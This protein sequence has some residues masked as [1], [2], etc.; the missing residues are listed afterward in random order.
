MSRHDSTTASSPTLPE[1]SPGLTL[2]SADEETDHAI[3]ALAV[4]HILSTG[5]TGYWVDPG[6]H[7]QTSPLVDLAPSDRI[8]DRIRV[9]RAFTAF[10]EFALL[11]SLPTLDAE[12]TEL[13]VV[14]EI[15]R[16][17]R[18]DD[19]LADEGRELLLGSLAALAAT[20]RSRQI[21]VLVTTR[22]EDRFTE[23]VERA[24][25]QTLACQS[26]PFGPRF[27][28]G[29]TETLV[30]P[31]EGGWVQTTLSFWERVLAAR[32]PLYDTETASPEVAYGA[33]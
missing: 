23:P 7:A 21:P 30:Y 3:H 19:L 1:L 33:N 28:S 24:A 10:Q 6:S 5:G 29:D 22:R 32:K 16:Y 8:L 15:D 4:D 9:A 25:S 31:R 2:L 13:V 20:A 14:P 17:Y 11:R 26:T 18:A 27:Q 12:Q